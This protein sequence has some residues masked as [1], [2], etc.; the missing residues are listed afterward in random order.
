VKEEIPAPA[1]IIHSISWERQ[2]FKVREF[3]LY[4]ADANGC[5][6]NSDAPA[7]IDKVSNDGNDPGGMTKAPIERSD[8]YFSRCFD[9]VHEFVFSDILIFVKIRHLFI[10]FD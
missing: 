3:S 9:R 2:V 1:G 8:H 5:G 4:H 7:G 6:G 10:L